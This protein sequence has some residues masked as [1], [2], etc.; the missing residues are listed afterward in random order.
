[1]V[2]V[3]P[4]TVLLLVMSG[5]SVSCNNVGFAPDVS[6]TNKRMTFK[7]DAP[8]AAASLVKVTDETKEPFVPAVNA[9]TSAPEPSRAVFAAVIKET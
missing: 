2:T 9:V 5:M 8:T 7:T 3:A 6:V 4:M 1:M